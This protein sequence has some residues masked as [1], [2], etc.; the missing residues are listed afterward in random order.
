MAKKTTRTSSSRKRAPKRSV[1]GA[2]A[3]TIDATEG[4]TAS[5]GTVGKRATRRGRRRKVVA[6]PR[7]HADCGDVGDVGDVGELGTN[8]SDHPN[9]H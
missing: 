8:A 2:L 9:R 6:D 3:A 1:E 5:A 4:E 7:L